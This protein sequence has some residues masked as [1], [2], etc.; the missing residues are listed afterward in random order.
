MRKAVEVGKEKKTG[1]RKKKVKKNGNNSPKAPRPPARVI[2][3]YLRVRDGAKL[4]EVLTELGFGTV[5]GWG[6]W[7]E[8]FLFRD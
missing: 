6:G 2:D 5:G 4:P 7:F 8:F 1:G 3:H